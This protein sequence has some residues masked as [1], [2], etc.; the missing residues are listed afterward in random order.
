MLKSPHPSGPDQSCPLTHAGYLGACVALSRVVPGCAL[1]DAS[2]RVQVRIRSRG[3]SVV[4]CGQV[5]ELN[6]GDEE[7]F[8][9]E[10]DI[11]PV[12]AQPRNLRLCSG[13]GRC[14]CEEHPS[15]FDTHKEPEC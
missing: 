2:P 9:V 13:D 12:W 7:W 6:A 4:L 10:T 1:R 5:V 15:V 11:G 14:T 3:E 8:R